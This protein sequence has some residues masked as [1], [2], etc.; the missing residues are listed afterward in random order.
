MTEPEWDKER[1][2]K[3][4]EEGKEEFFDLT[5][6]LNDLIVDFCLRAVKAAEASKGESLNPVQFV[7]MIRHEIEAVT[8][9]ILDQRFVDIVIEKARM[10]Y[11]EGREG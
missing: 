11:E 2:K 10:K 9:Q 3:A 8:Q 7:Q 1:L 4:M 5:F 6:K